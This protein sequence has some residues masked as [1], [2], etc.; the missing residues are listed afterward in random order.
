M[1]SSSAQHD[2]NLLSELIEMKRIYSV[3]E[4]TLF[5]NN[6]ACMVVTSGVPGEGKTTV[7]AGLSAVAALQRNLRILAIDL[8]WHRPDLHKWFGLTRKFDANNFGQGKSLLDLV[9]STHLKNLDIL[10][11]TSTSHPDIKMDE[12]V[13]RLGKDIIH[14]A[15]AAYDVVIVDA[16]S[17]FPV[18][19]C[20]MDPV[21]VSMDADAAILVALANVTP[22]Q[23]L[24]RARTLL[25]TAGVHVAGV[26]VNQWKNILF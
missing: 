1:N 15:R 25:E 9:Q 17:I 24:K 16:S 6:A 2:V 8:N 26:V 11:A 22:R 21:A 5:K 4:H 10:T 20:M 13:N 7:V 19:H 18:N 23:K 12:D 14:Q 3:I